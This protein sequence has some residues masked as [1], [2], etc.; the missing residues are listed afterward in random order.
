MKEF[1]YDENISIPEE[2]PE[3]VRRGVNDAKR[4]NYCFRNKSKIIVSLLLICC[5]TVGVN[6]DA[7]AFTA[8]LPIVKDIM[9]WFKSDPDIENFKKHNGKVFRAET[10]K[11]G[12]TLLIEDVYLTEDAISLRFAVED[13]NGEPLLDYDW[14]INSNIGFRFERDSNFIDKNKSYPW[15]HVNS[16]GIRGND[17]YY[18][19][20]MS[21]E[22][23]YHINFKDN[24][25]LK[26]RIQKEN[27]T[28]DFDEVLLE[29]A[30]ENIYDIKEIDINKE[31]EF[32]GDI[33]R[34][35]N[36][37]VDPIG[38][39]LNYS[40][41]VKD[42]DS[43]PDCGNKIEI[44]ALIDE[45]GNKYEMSTWIAFTESVPGQYRKPTYFNKSMYSKED[46]NIEKIILRT[47]EMPKIK[48]LKNDNKL[49][50]DE[51]VE[52]VLDENKYILQESDSTIKMDIY[53]ESM[54]KELFI[55]GKDGNWLYMRSNEEDEE[56]N[57]SEIILGEVE[58]MFNMSIDEI[59]SLE[60]EEFD[61]VKKELIKRYPTFNKMYYGKP[62]GKPSEEQLEN[63]IRYILE[64]T[65]KEG[66]VVLTGR[67]AEDNIHKYK[68]KSSLIK[69]PIE[70]GIR[71][72]EDVEIEEHTIDLK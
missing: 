10:K 30:E 38:M 58:M 69:R 46:I 60:G 18:H 65:K 37:K 53:S 31:I 64:E 14:T 16:R 50:D 11:N 21:R 20:C 52:V 28:I 54:R 9:M 68:I 27:E 42:K 34:I 19:E 71:E 59:L 39:I 4:A 32:N 45:M 57:F 22:F 41:K 66:R 67:G 15:N 63:S 6:P 2:L 13:N 25:S 49:N 36:L 17:V 48:S 24:L 33:L 1:K 26:F 3:C 43:L 47:T 70:I 62:Y 29:T 40:Y 5:I 35:Y 8:G 12:Y 51:K 44:V 61:L 72:D 55:K 56:N 7:R 23:S